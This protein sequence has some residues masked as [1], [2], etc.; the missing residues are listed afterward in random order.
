MQ[1][2]AMSHLGNR[3][4]EI[5]L[6]RYPTFTIQL[7][8]DGSGIYSMHLVNGMRASQATVP[9]FHNAILKTARLMDESED[10]ALI[11]LISRGPN[12]GESE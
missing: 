11:S 2:F 12:L 9:N 7:T 5:L 4:T 10:F 3:F 8:Q 1:S 6:D